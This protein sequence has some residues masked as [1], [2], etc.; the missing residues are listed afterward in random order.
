MVIVALQ[1]REKKGRQHI[2]Y[3]NSLLTSVPRDSL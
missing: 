2:P 3:R 1:E